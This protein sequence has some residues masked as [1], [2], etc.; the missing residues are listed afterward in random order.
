MTE[1]KTDR[2]SW[3]YDIETLK[4]C[5]T[6]TAINVDTNEIVQYVLHID[7][8]GLDELMNHLLLCKGQIG[9]NNINFDYPIIHYLMLN[10]K[11]WQYTLDTNQ[12]IK[13]LYNKAQDIIT[14]QS[15]KNF[16]TIVAIP[17]KEV[18]IPQL[19]LFK[20]WHF[21][22]K[23]RSTSLKSLEIAMNMPNV[24]EM[25]ISHTRDDIK[26]SEIKSIL[27]YNLNDVLATLEFYKRSLGKIELRKGLI[28]KYN[29][30]CLNFPD[31]KIG[32]E[33]TLKLY[34]EAT[35]K[36][37]WEVKKMR[38][39]RSII[40]LKDCIFDYIKFNSKELNDFLELLKSKSIKETK[41]ELKY[42]VIYKG[43]KYDFGSGGIH[44]CIK[45]GLYESDDEYIIIDADV[46]SLY[47]SI[48]IINKLYPE[49][50]GK[51]FCEVYEKGIV[52][53]RLIAKKSGD[54]IMADG[55]KLSANSV[56]GK[57]NDEHS[58]LKDPMYTMKTTINGQLMLVMLAESLVDSFGSKITILQ[59]NTDG[60]T[61]KI[62][63]EFESSYYALCKLWEAQ[64]NLTLEYVEYDKMWIR[65]VNNYG[66][67]S[68][69]GKIKNKGAFEIDKDYHKDNS[70]KIIPIALQNYFVNN[71]PVEDTITGH[72]NIYDFCGRQKFK[73]G[74]SY[75]T[76]HY[77]KED[78]VVIEEQQRNVRYYVSNK[79][80]T[81]I[82]NYSKGTSEVIN[83]GYQVTIFNKFIDKSIKDYDI[84]YDFY[85]KECY[86][87]INLI[88]D[89]QMK[90]EL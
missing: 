44:G 34:C 60:I 74:E 81:F 14:Q 38:T 4:S 70:F 45:P 20:L 66:C 42:S 62:P 59:I 37:I 36:D 23:A 87:E 52:E 54:T 5:F 78:K 35:G 46:A 80:A 33:L 13:L 89:K 48:A 10:Y 58:F 16:T 17:N 67:L 90:L 7:R 2:R 1:Q 19:D 50:L 47:P 24:M 40:H 88:N 18:K 43:F 64:T 57:S 56:Y 41:G 3:V 31:T 30:P 68:T 29:L 28:Q 73:T 55:F 86:K 63:R 11:K 83:K 15:S 76:I 85:I 49:H 71:I 69:K 39:D 9:F 61:V 65:D 82:K 79:G 22:N 26:E 8:D 72:Q 25:P 12:I 53:P 6:Y 32:E 51:E 75:G 27:E 77:I 21:N 84:N